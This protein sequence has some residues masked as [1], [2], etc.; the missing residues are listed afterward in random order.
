VHYEVWQE[1]QRYV[2]LQLVV[3][4][5][6]DHSHSAA[7]K[8]PDKREAPKNLLPRTKSADGLS[9]VEFFHERAAGPRRICSLT[10]PPTFDD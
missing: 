5:K 4:G 1:L 10:V 6:P 3:P 9:Q 2:P 8:N 7:A